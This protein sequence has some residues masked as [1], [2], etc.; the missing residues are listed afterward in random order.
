MQNRY[1]MFKSKHFTQ[2]IADRHIKLTAERENVLQSLC[3]EF[4]LIGFVY[5]R[6]GTPYRFVKDFGAKY[7]EDRFEAG[8][9][10]RANTDLLGLVPKDPEIIKRCQEAKTVSLSEVVLSALEFQP[11]T[12]LHS[13]PSPEVKLVKDIIMVKVTEYNDLPYNPPVTFVEIPK[14]L[15]NDPIVK[16]LEKHLTD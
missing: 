15:Y 13:E 5:N 6:D 4:E 7:D 16:L 8:R 2:V 9:I 10:Q 1:F 12:H 3:D 11:Q 14:S